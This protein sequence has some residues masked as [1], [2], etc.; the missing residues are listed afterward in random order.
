MFLFFF[1]IDNTFFTCVYLPPAPPL[2][3]SPSLL[4]AYPLSMVSLPPALSSNLFHALHK[5]PLPSSSSHSVTSSFK[6][7]QAPTYLS[8]LPHNLLLVPPS[9]SFHLI[10]LPSTPILYLPV[11][12]IGEQY[13]RPP[14][15]SFPQ[16]SEVEFV[17]AFESLP[18]CH[19][20]IQPRAGLVQFA[21]K[22]AASGNK[23][24]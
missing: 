23:R 10:P 13:L 18:R 8:P 17:G 15:L 12:H 2:V 14:Q 6:P 5:L 22:S 4:T 19:L 21:L 7:F 20:F 3:F 9:S 24:R 11:L 16:L 1:P